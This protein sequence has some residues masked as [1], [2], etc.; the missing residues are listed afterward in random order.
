M[1]AYVVNTLMKV[2]ASSGQI[3]TARELFES[4]VDPPPGHPGL[5]NHPTP[6]P[7]PPPSSSPTTLVNTPSSNVNSSV[8]KIGDPIYR[9]PSCYETIIRIE[10]G[11]GNLEQVKNLVDRLEGRGYP[12]AIV[13]RIKKLV[14]L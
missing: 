7:S 9:E 5:F 12:K 14:N 8:G 11:L 10:F 1:T 2:Y 6:S 4:L 13:N 3:D